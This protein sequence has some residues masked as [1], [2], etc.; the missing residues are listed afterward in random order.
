MAGMKQ[1]RFAAAVACTA[2]AA[3][4]GIVTY[5]AYDARI[6]RDH[7]YA[8]RVAQ[9]GETRPLTVYNHCE[10]SILERRT[11]GGDVNR[12]F[13]E[14]A[15]DGGPARV[16]IA[17][18][19]DVKSYAVFPSRL[20]LKSEFANGVLSVTLDRPANFGVRINDLDKSILSVFADA[21]EDAAKVPRKGAPG[22]LYVDGWVD[23]P[24]ED[25]V[26]TVDDPVREVYVAPGAVLNA[27]LVVKA[28][29]AYVHGRGMILDPFSDIFRFDQKKNTRRGILTVSASGV[30]VEDA[31]LV[32]AR[33]FNYCTW[34]DGVVFRNVKALSTMMCTD[35][36]T[37]GGRDLRVEG[38]WLYV[39][40]NGLVIS[41]VRGGS[42]RNVAIGTSC[43]AIFPQSSNEGVSLENV[44]VFRADE[45]CIKNSYN[46]V[47]RRNTKW[48]E[49]N[50][51]AAKKEPGP[52]DLPHQRQEFFFRNLSAVDCVLFA[53]FFLGGNM[54]TLPKTFAFEN[55]SIPFC[56]GKADWRAAGERG[57]AIVSVMHDP[58]KWLDTTGYSLAVTNLWL[59]GSRCDAIPAGLVENADRVS[60]SV[61]STPGGPAIPAVADR[62]ETNWTCPFKRYVGASLQRDV[63]K[64]SRKS[65]ERRIAQPDDGENLL[66]DRPSTRSAWQ[67]HP[68]WLSKFDATETEDG[69]RVYR[70]VQCERNAGMQNVVTDA[71]LRHGN[72]TYR[73]SFEARAKC[74]APAAVEA[75]FISNEKRIVE[76]FTV[77]ADGAWHGFGSD[78]ELDFDL[79]ETEL[80]SVFLRSAGPCDELSFRR[81]SLAKKR[82]STALLEGEIPLLDGER[83]WGGG[84]GDGQSQPYG[85]GNSRRI[86]LRTHGNA[87]SPLLVSSCGRYVWSEKPFAYEFRD[88][89]LLIDSG[90]ETVGCVQAGKTLKDAYL[91][92]AKA[93]MRFDGRMP[94]DVFFSLPQWN[95]WIEL[96]MNG[97][98]Q[99][100]ADD[101]TEELAKSGFPC[102][103]YMMDG[104]WLSHQGSY[105]FYERDYPDP[106]GMFDRINANGWI[107]LIWTAHFV[108]P[109]SRE[110]KRLR[111]K[112][113]LG[114][115]DYL[116]YRRQPGSHD[117]AVVRWW[118]GISAV[119]DLTKPEANA[120]YAKTLHDFAVRYGIRGFKF[121]AGDP[122][123]FA[124]DCRFHD[125]TAEPVDYTRLYAELA[126]REFPYHEIRVGWKC[127]GLPLVMRLNDC[128]HAWTGRNAQDTV[129][130]QVI[131]AGLVGYPYLVA[132]M[133]GG[134]LE[135][136]F[137]GKKIDE[138]LFVRSAALQA[139]MPMMQFSPAPWR[140]LSPEGVEH[141]RKLAGLHVEFAPY[142][143]ETAR[144]AAKTGEPI[145]RA[146]EYE[147]P[148][149]GF[150]RPMQQ[151]ML[152]SRWLVA[153]VTT[154]DDAKMVELP[155][156]RWRDDLGETHVGPGTLHLAGVPL[157]R[158]PR[159]ERLGE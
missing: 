136:S 114:G 65:G 4:G 109:D 139:L 16:D 153:P 61:A 119:Y 52:Q 149:Q 88:G 89:K 53:R 126:A 42:F 13:C 64:V 138:R 2:L 145:V 137:V 67:R 152:G 18:C 148:H 107:P 134:G 157:G 106:K 146:M 97:M 50:T 144:H 55:V 121:D 49:M 90:A 96:F 31:K 99:K 30:T 105:E 151:F 132:D 48:N 158:L 115:L 93:H 75:L 1:F 82:S 111:H 92:A 74:D 154:P 10:K 6:E 56:T 84:G 86:D 35:G 91:A 63:R 27:R 39:G 112:P 68:S 37:C 143:L 159:Y 5:P 100:A 87:S 17:F 69:E 120:Y 135:S 80:L 15:F 25:G 22:V 3:R 47:L 98:D 113:N 51:G 44:D 9:G 77:P 147:F 57:G 28:K 19:E 76:K 110:Y 133:V 125:E 41:G 7:A 156:G 104:G 73:L 8:V 33:T 40:D 83:W 142:I 117:A 155:S 70:L 78:V 140:R 95:N 116:A 141:C 23:P 81:L 124:E 20:G 58:E 71:F 62:H 12:R 46:G 54:G 94:P 102:G 130:P 21:P 26:L 29:G 11:R 14:F 127:G 32:D 36:I 66:A 59:G 24:G 129:I 122:Y 34:A 108:S 123:F 43:N 150:N 79:G 101:Y 38:A 131:A 85:A 103:V 128:A 45:G 60:V 72:G 118:S